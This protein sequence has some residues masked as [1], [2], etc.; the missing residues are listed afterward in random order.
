[1]FY[2]YFLFKLY[3]LCKNDNII[4]TNVYV[5][6]LIKLCD[7]I[8]LDNINLFQNG[9]WE[10]V[11]KYKNLSNNSLD[12]NFGYKNEYHISSIFSWLVNISFYCFKYKETKKCILCYLLFLES[13][14]CTPL[15]SIKNKEI[16]YERL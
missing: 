5:D 2:I 14:F 8:I 11:N 9:I 1:M 7:K 6:N 10:I 13:K 12:D 16:I 15:I 4:K 3:N